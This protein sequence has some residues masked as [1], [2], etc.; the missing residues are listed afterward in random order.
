[1]Q[2]SCEDIAWFD[3]Y[4]LC[5]GPRSQV[6]YIEIAK[7]YTTVIVSN[8]PQF[9]TARDDMARRFINL[10]DEFYDRHVKL[11]VSAEVEI[12]DIYKGTQLAFEYDRTVSRLLEMQSEEYLSLEHR[13]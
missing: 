4:A 9:D 6:D 2:N 13:P 5:D 8:V 12:P 10:V 7:L 11:I 1:L 3:V